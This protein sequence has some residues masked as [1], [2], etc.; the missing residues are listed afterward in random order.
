MRPALAEAIAAHGHEEGYPKGSVVLCVECWKPLYVLE[1]GIG[2]GQR[3]SRSVGC[4]RPMTAADFKALAERATRD[5]SLNP[6]LAGLWRSWT[7][8]Q[9]Q[10]MADRIRPP[11]TGEDAQCPFCGRGW[12]FVRA[13]EASEAIDKAYVWELLTIPPERPVPVGVLR[14][15]SHG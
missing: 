9:R 11:K 8:E 4:Y 5:H 10:A 14:A 12:V 1:H 3:A 2:I 6:G 13:T 15:W 7:P